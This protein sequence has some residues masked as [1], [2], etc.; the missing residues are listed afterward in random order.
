MKDIFT[1]EDVRKIFKALV[2]VYGEEEALRLLK[3]IIR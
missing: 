1:S 3:K 2:K